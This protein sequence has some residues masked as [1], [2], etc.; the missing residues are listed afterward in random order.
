MDPKGSNSETQAR[1]CNK[2]TQLAK[3]TSFDAGEKT[4]LGVLMGGVVGT[5]N[6]T[7][8]GAMAGNVGK[9]AST[10]S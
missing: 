4:G 1:D 5:V 8:I 9:D 3:D 2:Y 10:Q 7:V 6:E